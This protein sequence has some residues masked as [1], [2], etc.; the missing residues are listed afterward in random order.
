[1]ILSSLLF[2]ITAFNIFKEKK[3]FF[4]LI[5]TL[6]YTIAFPLNSLVFG[7]CYLGLGIMII[8]LLFCTML[9]IKDF[10][11]RLIFNIT[12]LF[13]INFCL[14][15]S[16][17]LF[18]PCIYLGLGIYY[19]YLWKKK[20]MTFKNLLLYG[21]ATLILPFAIG[22]IYFL[23]PGFIKTGGTSVL[24][25]VSMDGYIYN[26]ET[27]RYFFI[28]V[29]IIFLIR[30][31]FKKEKLDY[32]NFSFGVISGYIIL[33]Y[34]LYFLDIV[35]LY[36]FY[37][38]FYLY[39]FFVIIF[40]GKLL[41]NRCELLYTLFILILLGMSIV[42]L[43]PNNKF[44][45]FLVNINIF[46]WNINT[47]RDD[48]IIFNEKELLLLNK[49]IDYN[50]LCSVNNKFLISGDSLKNVW[51]YA[52]N[53]NIPLYGYQYNHSRCLGEPNITFN[54]WKS[55]NKYDCL[56]YF[57]E[58]NKNNYDEEDYEILYSNEAGA[59]LKRSSKK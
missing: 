45:N 8:N 57:Y 27:S 56:V 50:E 53:N 40:M 59:I 37:K 35:G 11:K 20:K 34:I 30:C 39:W 32:F 23:L 26:N 9:R 6:L 2:F 3:I 25:A 21:F 7:F 44:S 48:K 14:F 15:F 19:I 12:I 33:F 10:N 24:S 55:I 54:Y 29:S 1:M 46:C 49:S 58:D 42:Y 5:L 47:F 38:L 43:F 17:Y 22:F 41:V 36:Y 4:S 28:I 18:V 31:V 13:M 16:Y 52:F 51:F